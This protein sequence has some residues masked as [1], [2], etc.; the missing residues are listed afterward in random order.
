MRRCGRTNMFVFRTEDKC[1][2]DV[3]TQVKFKLDQPTVDKGECYSFSN[4]P[5]I[6]P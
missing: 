5:D 2:V 3:Q 1:W 6:V 4:L